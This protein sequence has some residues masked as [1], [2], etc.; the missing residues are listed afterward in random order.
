MGNDVT[1][2]IAIRKAINYG[3]DRQEIIENVLYGY[4]EVIFDFLIHYLGELK[5]NK[6]KN[7]KMVI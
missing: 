1:S 6:K 5:M 2:D 4:G 3:V 7:L